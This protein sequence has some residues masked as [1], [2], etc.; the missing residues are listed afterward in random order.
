MAFD[1]FKQLKEL[2]SKAKE[3]E[4][5]LAGVTATES[6]KG[7]TFTMSGNLE[8]INV[9]I[10]ADSLRDDPGYVE[11][12]VKKGINKTIKAVQ[13]KSARKMMKEGGIEGFPGLG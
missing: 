12:I 6:H 5:Q 3:V 4:S 11:D 7:W 2:R 10:D 1:K 8:L 13:Q 9:E